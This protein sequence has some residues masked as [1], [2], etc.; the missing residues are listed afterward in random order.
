M[1]VKQISPN[2]I[3]E[4][5]ADWRTGEYSQRDLAHKHKVSL[6]FVSKHT[7][8]VGQD[9]NAVVNAG[10]EYRQGLEGHDERIVNAVHHAVDE[11]T[12]HI[13]LFNN[14][15]ANNAIR[16]SQLPCETQQDHERLSNTILRSKEVVLG[17]SP[18]VAVQVNNQGMDKEERVS[19]YLPSNSR[20]AD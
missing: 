8:G 19:F 5:V 6:G 3:A 2:K 10:I 7:K 15:A 11:R 17:K 13:L 20:D 16:A 18:D 9:M 1:A 4:I 14:L 12:K